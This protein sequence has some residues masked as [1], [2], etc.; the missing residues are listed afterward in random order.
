MIGY[1]GNESSQHRE[2]KLKIAR[3]A[4]ANGGLFI[5]AVEINERFQT[6]R[7]DL[8]GARVVIECDETG[9][10]IP[11]ANAHFAEYGRYPEMIFDVGFVRDGQVIAAIEIVR[12]S[13]ITE[14]KREKILRAGVLCV[15]VKAT[16]QEWY[17]DDSRIEAIQVIA[18]PQAKA[19]L[20]PL[21]TQRART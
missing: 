9:A 21:S 10:E 16:L 2:A 13:G 17:V 6:F 1:A 19:H 12:S 11:D 4:A 5:V 15:A 14:R 18:P 3:M 8:S 20:R 7:L